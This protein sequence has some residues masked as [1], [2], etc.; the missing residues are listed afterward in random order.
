MF[1]DCKHGRCQTRDVHNRDWNSQNEKLRLPSVA[2][3]CELLKSADH[4]T[5]YFKAT[6]N[7][8]FKNEMCLDCAYK[9]EIACS[10]SL[11]PSYA[12]VGK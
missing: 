9:I 5:A 6:Q 10:V 4:L 1:V 8:K 12:V 2:E 3:Q 7:V 11:V